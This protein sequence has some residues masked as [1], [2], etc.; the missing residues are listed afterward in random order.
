MALGLNKLFKKDETTPTT[1]KF[2]ESRIPFQVQNLEKYMRS[3]IEGQ[4]RAIKQFLRAY[5]T[6]LTNMQRPDAPI[7]VLLFLGPTGVGKTRMVEVFAEY[8]WGNADALIKIDC[9]EFQHSHEIAKLIGAPPGYVGHTDT[10]PMLTKERIEKYWNNGPK[11]TPVLFDEIEKAHDNLHR[12]LLGINGAGRVTTGKN[13]TIDMRPT[14]IVM[15]SNLGSRSIIGKLAGKT[16]GFRH[17]EK[18]YSDIDDEIYKDCKDAVK[19][20]FPSE[21]Y[22]RIDRIVAFRPL[23][24]DNFR[25]ILAI[26]LSNIQDRIIKA[27]K[28]IILDVSSR[29][30]NFLLK[31]GV[32]REYGARELRR[33][34]ERFLVGKLT[35]AFS[36]FQ[37][38]DGDLILADAESGDDIDLTITKNVVDLPYASVDLTTGETWIRPEATGPFESM[39]KPGRCGRCAQPWVVDHVCSDIQKMTRMTEAVKKLPPSALTRYYYRDKPSVR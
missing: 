33:T 27:K 36:T 24:E 35:R 31:E 13:E 19:A 22:N 26:E 6:F 32:S 8:L 20:F 39:Y 10:K 14:L 34:I 30:K 7:G 38:V 15:T 28:Y 16:F 17:E 11:F 12:I 5:E 21:F 9:S 25:N 23:T 18:S 4:D 3:K 37:A 1:I 2:D 29:A